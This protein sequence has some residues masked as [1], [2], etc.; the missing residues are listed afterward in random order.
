M[1]ARV[2]WPA[3]LLGLLLVLGIHLAG[4]DDDPRELRDYYEYYDYFE[5]LA[6]VVVE[7][8]AN[9]VEDVD[10]KRLFEG[11]IKGMLRELDPYSA[12]IPEEMYSIFRQDTQ[13]FFGGLGIHI[14]IRDEQLTVIAPLEGT[15][16]ARAG[17]LPGDKIVRIEGESTEGVTL[18]EAVNVL[19]GEP[20]SQVT[21]TIR[22]VGSEEEIDVTITRE[23]IEIHSVRGYRRL[24]NGEGWDYWVNPEEK[25]GYIRLSAFQENTV[26]EL[27]G[28]INTLVA[29]GVR[30]L[31]LDLRSNAGG[32]LGAAVAV[33][34]RFL[35]EGVVVSI[36]GRVEGTKEE[37]AHAD[38]DYP[39][40]ML[41]AVLVNRY[42]ASG[43][44][45]VA[46]AL[47][48]YSRA[49]LI[50]EETFGKGSVQKVIPLRDN[51]SAIKLTTAKY[52]T[53]SGRSFHRDPR[54]KKGGLVPDITV[55]FT[56]EQLGQLHR[57]W[58]MLAV[59]AEQPEPTG[60][61]EVKPFVDTQLQRATDLLIGLHVV[62]SAID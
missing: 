6:R 3:A 20:G 29:E 41:L 42:S 2:L 26:A 18:L 39:A 21:I 47:Q 19:R 25:I 30:G 31:V 54:T 10:Q 38:D 14:G 55:A 52:Y 46:G 40:E 34:D 51:A 17:I 57:R 4:Q 43:S 11:S 61:E 12:Y 45:I 33:A 1:S 36:R 28:V 16:A 59:E 44:E 49:T 9:Y 22:H 56:T 13:G 35:P 60:E 48:D 7:I 15:P 8:E 23:I 5:E 62:R 24:A 32:L 37:R 53:P 50:G 27:D 58:Q